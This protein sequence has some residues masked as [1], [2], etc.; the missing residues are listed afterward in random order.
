MTFLRGRNKFI[1]A[2]KVRSRLLFDGDE[3]VETSATVRAFK[4]SFSMVKQS[5]NYFNVT[6]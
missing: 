1:L 5:R 4:N 6:E 3:F 2:G